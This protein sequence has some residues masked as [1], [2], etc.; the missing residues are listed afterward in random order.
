MRKIGADN[1]IVNCARLDT[2]D[3][4]PWLSRGTDSADMAKIKVNFETS[5]VRSFV[6]K[7]K[8]IVDTYIKPKL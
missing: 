2:F 6:N 5:N 1:E 8:D 4:T 7:N 3:F